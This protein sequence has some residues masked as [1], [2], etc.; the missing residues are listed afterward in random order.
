MDQLTC[1][2]EHI[3]ESGKLSI[4]VLLFGKGVF[5]DEEVKQKILGRKVLKHKLEATVTI[6]YCVRQCLQS[7]PF[8]ELFSKHCA[9]LKY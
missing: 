5:K 2:N 6:A 4:I 9:Y 7:Q 1:I 3:I 8:R